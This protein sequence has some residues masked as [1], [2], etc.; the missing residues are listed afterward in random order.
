L[1]DFAGMFHLKYE[2]FSGDVFQ[3]LLSDQSDTTHAVFQLDCF[4][5]NMQVVT[6]WLSNRFL[7]AKNGEVFISE[8]SV[9]RFQVLFLESFH[10]RF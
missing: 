10:T 2:S 3:A 5:K 6:L 9:C 7:A 4:L 8:N 1:E